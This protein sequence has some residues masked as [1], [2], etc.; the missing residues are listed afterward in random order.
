MS[1][2]T[3]VKICPHKQFSNYN[4][5]ILLPQFVLHIDYN[6]IKNYKLYVQCKNS[7]TFA[8]LWLLHNTKILYLIMVENKHTLKY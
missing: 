7:G 6:E 1:R 5:G 4:P 2:Q 8:L 3:L